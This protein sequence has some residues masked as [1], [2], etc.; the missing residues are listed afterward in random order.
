MKFQ[1]TI[2]LDHA[3]FEDGPDEL[4]QL[5]RRIAELVAEGRTGYPI[6]DSNGN[7]VGEWEITRT[8]REEAEEG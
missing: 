1:A 2:K 3:A 8:P 5:L 4:A 7:R 6:T